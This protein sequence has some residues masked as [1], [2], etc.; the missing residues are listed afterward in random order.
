MIKNII[1]GIMTLLGLAILLY[2]SSYIF[3]CSTVWVS[4]WAYP[5]RGAWIFIGI[6]LCFA[7][8]LLAIS[9]GG[10]DGKPEKKV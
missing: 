8:A 5:Q 7:G 3:S 9:G 4:M 2:N 6:V 10:S 1:G